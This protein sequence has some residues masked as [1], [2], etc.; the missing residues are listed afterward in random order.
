MAYYGSVENY[1]LS[2]CHQQ[3]MS[4]GAMLG[5]TILDEDEIQE[6]KVLYLFEYSIS[7]DIYYAFLYNRPRTN[8][9]IY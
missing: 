3:V 6:E 5:E 4:T 9:K 1:E 2:S 8:K 7:V